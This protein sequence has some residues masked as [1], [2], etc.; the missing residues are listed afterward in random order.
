MRF[1]NFNLILF[2]FLFSLSSLFAQEK[3]IG[4]FLGAK[5]TVMPTWFLN[6][7][8]DLKEDIEEQALNNKR[9]IL[10]VHQASCPYCNKFVTKNLENKL[11]KEKIQKHF[12]VID[13]N[14]FG[15]REVTDI[16]ENIYTEKEFAKKYK[17]QF[18]PTIIFFNEEGQHILKLNGYIPVE[19]F[20][21]ALDYV[22]D[23]KETFVT[24]S[25]Y[26]DTNS[27]QT[28]NIDILK[29]DLFMKSA[30]VLRRDI[31][32]KPLAVFFESDKCTSC[33]EV[34]S[35]FLKDKVIQTLLPK[36]DLAKIDINST[37]TIATPDKIIMKTKAWVKNLKIT[38][39]PSIIFFNEQGKE[40][41]RIESSFKT[42]HTQSIVDYV[43]SGAYKTE[44]EFQRY[45]TKRA[46]AIREKGID[47][48]IWD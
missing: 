21:I 12:A 2:L 37:Q 38:Y 3:E 31:N 9:L 8:L 22:K 26:L 27:Q 15:D 18:T 40:I 16:D 34:H 33:Q 36:L 19:T 46:N 44:P 43:S 30:K 6:T 45:L 39:N 28:K 29:N 47:V 41:I 20:N 24:Y 32:N 11:I 4:K 25:Q 10:F 48:N 5:D 13:I 1:K 7:F 42:F 17:I 14:M 35:F 23:K